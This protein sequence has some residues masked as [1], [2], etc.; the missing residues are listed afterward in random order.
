MDPG[1]LQQDPQPDKPQARP[2]SPVGLKHRV[3]RRLEQL[4]A[5]A[6]VVAQHDFVASAQQ[7]QPLAPPLPDHEG[8][9]V[10]PGPHQVLHGP[11]QVG[12]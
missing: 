12:V 10:V 7:T 1:N 9:P 4:Q 6:Q 2:A 8:E 11:K 5:E 3:K